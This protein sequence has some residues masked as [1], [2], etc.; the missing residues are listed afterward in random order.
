MKLKNLLD[1]VDD[2]EY[3]LNII[4]WTITDIEH[5]VSEIGFIPEDI[6]RRKSIKLLPKCKM[7][8]NLYTK[9]EVSLRTFEGNLSVLEFNKLKF[10]ECVKEDPEQFNKLEIRLEFFNK[11]R[12]AILKRLERK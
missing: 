10:K 7:L 3:D 6:T 9:L 8:K 11:Q 12:D 2:L 1:A 4:K 5:L